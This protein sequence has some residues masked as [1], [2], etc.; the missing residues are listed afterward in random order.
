MGT[1]FGYMDLNPERTT[2]EDLFNNFYE[3]AKRVV[4]RDNPDQLAQFE[5]DK[6]N[7]RYVFITGMSTLHYVLQYLSG[8]G[9][10]PEAVSKM[11]VRLEEEFKKEGN[12]P[13]VTAPKAGHA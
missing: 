13:W 1:E 12:M 4:A 5:A 10:E 7:I 3:T 11:L 2:V 6:E 9:C 8:R